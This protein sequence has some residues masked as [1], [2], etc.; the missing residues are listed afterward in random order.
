MSANIDSHA[1][2]PQFQKMFRIMEGFDPSSADA[3]ADMLFKYYCAGAQA[4]QQNEP[5]PFAAMGL[6]FFNPVC[7]CA[8]CAETRR[9][10]HEKHLGPVSDS[11]PAP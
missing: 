6:H 5:D 4:F 11:K 7:E 10:L 2:W 8:T 9:Y 3:R 1:M